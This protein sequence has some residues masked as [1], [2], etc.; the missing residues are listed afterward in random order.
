MRKIQFRA[1][2]VVNEQMIYYGWN[3]RES[4]DVF[5]THQDMFNMGDSV[6]LQQFTGLLDKNGKE[7]YEGDI[8]ND[9]SIVDDNG[10]PF[11]GVVGFKDSAFRYIQTNCDCGECLNSIILAGIDYV[12]GNIHQHPNLLK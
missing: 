5:Y 10:T 8:L 9:H 2:H 11:R 1:W 4:G 3:K 6:I 7:I 12:I